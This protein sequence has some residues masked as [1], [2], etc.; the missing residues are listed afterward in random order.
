MTKDF[1]Y[2]IA[3]AR[4]KNGRGI[5]RFRTS[6]GEI[7]NAYDSAVVTYTDIESARLSITAANQCIVRRISNG[8]VTCEPAPP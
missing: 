4:M 2:V 6:D 7:A 1:C 5:L 8:G 3:V